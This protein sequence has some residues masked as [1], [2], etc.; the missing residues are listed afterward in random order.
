M[1]TINKDRLTLGF[2]FQKAVVILYALINLVSRYHTHLV[3]PTFYKNTIF[4][5]IGVH[6]KMHIKL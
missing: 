4:V 1:K 2:D 5:H 3:T 6:K